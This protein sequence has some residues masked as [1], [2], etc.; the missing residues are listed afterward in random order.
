MTF[1]IPEDLVLQ[2]HLHVGKR[3]LSRFISTAIRKA[4][5]EEEIQEENELD[6]AYEEANKDPTRLEALKDWEHI[7]D[8]SDLGNDEDWEWLK[9]G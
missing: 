6:K 4:L 9:N 8:I 7:D 1:S 3:G 5:I 2:L